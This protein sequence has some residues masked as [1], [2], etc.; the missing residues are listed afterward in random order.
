LTVGT[1]VLTWDAPEHRGSWADHGVPGIYMGPAVDHL[2]AFEVWVP[3][4]S[5]LRI[6]NT[7]WW[8]LENLRPD[9]SLLQTDQLSAFPPSRDHPHPRDDGTDL[10]GRYFMEPELGVCVILGSGPTA[11]KR[12]DSRAQRKR[13][14]SSDIPVLRLGT[15]FTLTYR[16]ADTGEEHF[17]SVDEI[18]FWIETGPL[19]KPPP[20]EP[21]LNP[22]AAPVTIPRSSRPLSN[23][24][25]CRRPPTRP[26]LEG[27]SC[28]RRSSR[29]KIK[30]C[31][32]ARG[33]KGCFPTPGIK[34]C[35]LEIMS[36]RTHDAPHAS[37]SCVRSWCVPMHPPPSL[38]PTPR[39]RT[40]PPRARPN[41]P[42]RL[43]S[44]APRPPA[45]RAYMTAPFRP[46]CCNPGSPQ[47]R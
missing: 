28:R 17:S 6:T 3:S 13:L 14:R 21:D 15:H 36:R 44:S 4:S 42:P 29:P 16:Q 19:L 5:T 43:T 12:M 34:G 41:A 47:A 10:I 20:T 9:D 35:P 1:K 32:P 45:P 18:L 40:H 24:S 27:S 38:Q 39:L 2:R 30:G 7:V 11:T 33:I 26:H 25:P 22:L 31:F 37:P 23:M 8:F 46:R